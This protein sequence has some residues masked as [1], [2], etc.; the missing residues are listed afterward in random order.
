MPRASMLRRAAAGKWYMDDGRGEIVH[1][2]HRRRRRPGAGTWRVSVI[3]P[4]AN[5]SIQL[6]PS[7]SIALSPAPSPPGDSRLSVRKA[8][9]I[10]TL[11]GARPCSRSMGPQLP[12]LRAA[13]PRGVRSDG[14]KMA[15]THFSPNAARREGATKSPLV[16]WK[17]RPR[18]RVT[19]FRALRRALRSR[20]LAQ[21]TF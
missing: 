17:L 19:H 4:V 13:A 6:L 5:E 2:G 18:I 8:E 15:Q 11:V 3:F 10:S 1:A 21:P 9:T 12:G 7:N 20:L 16:R 14:D